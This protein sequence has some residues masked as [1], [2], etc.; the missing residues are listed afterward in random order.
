MFP[1]MKM[2]LKGRRFKRIEEIQ[3]ESPAALQAATETAL[4]KIFQH[5]KTRGDRCIAVQGTTSRVMVILGFNFHLD[6][7]YEGSPGTF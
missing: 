4:R 5:W 3:K 6:I 7:F 1:R 2:H